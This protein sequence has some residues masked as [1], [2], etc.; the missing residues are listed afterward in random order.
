MGKRKEGRMSSKMTVS[1]SG[2]GVSGVEK[3]VLGRVG[4]L[5]GGI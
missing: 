5:S 2:D 1:G 4:V 3:G